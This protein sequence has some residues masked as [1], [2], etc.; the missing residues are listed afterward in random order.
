[1]AKLGMKLIDG[2]QLPKNSTQGFNWL[3]Q[4]A[5]CATMEYPEGLYEYA[6]LHEDG[7]STHCFRD[8][9]FMVSL[10]QAA[11][12]ARYGPATCKLAYGYAHGLWG[13][14]KSH[15]RAFDHYSVASKL[16]HSPSF[17]P[18]ALYYSGIIARVIPPSAK[19][20]YNFM[21]KAADCGHARAAEL[22]SVFRACQY[23]TGVH[24]FI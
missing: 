9:T 6:L 8:H 19:L 5:N 15:L 14:E 21:S 18:L 24:T 20:A 13:L 3:R 22:V 2:S 12:D 11:S 7:F 10:L 23:G 1:M 17:Y 16:G 4:A